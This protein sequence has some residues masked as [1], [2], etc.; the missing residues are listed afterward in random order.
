MCYFSVTTA[1]GQNVYSDNFDNRT[2]YNV[3]LHKN[4]CINKVHL[5]E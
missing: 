5:L 2:V 3:T 1:S 4:M